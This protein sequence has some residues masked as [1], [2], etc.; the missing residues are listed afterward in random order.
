MISL[1][2]GISIVNH[3]GAYT[4]RFPASKKKGGDFYLNEDLINLT[5]EKKFEKVSTSMRATISTKHLRPFL[6][7]LEDS[8][9]VN[10]IISEYDFERIQKQAIDHS[11]KVKAI[12]LPPQETKQDLKIIKFKAKALTIKLKLLNQLNRAS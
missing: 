1:S 2:H 8:F 6:T 10:I 5:N 4:V 11:G 7:K 9:K 12:E 3:N